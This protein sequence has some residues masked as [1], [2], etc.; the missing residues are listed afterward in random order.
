MDKI[1]EG[2]Y[3]HDL[4]KYDVE[5]YSRETVS[6]K[7]GSGELEIGTVLELDSTGAYKPLTYTAAE[8]NTSASVGTPAGV[9]IKKVDAT[10]AAVNATIIARQAV[11][12]EDELIWPDDIDSTCLA[13][14][15]GDLTSIGII[16][17]KGA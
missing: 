9:L 17:R 8:S 3:V 14:A 15:A 1:S 6:I 13:E 10:S 7:S 4:V 5:I 12:V 2:K 11:V 16:A